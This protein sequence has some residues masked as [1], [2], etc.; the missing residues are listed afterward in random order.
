MFLNIPPALE[1]CA[2]NFVSTPEMI[3]IRDQF[4]SEDSTTNAKS[5]SIY[6]TKLSKITI[7][8]R[9]SL[10]GNVCNNQIETN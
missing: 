4:S 5:N 6:L 2:P 8:A 7:E 10:T 1:I 9:L 3:K